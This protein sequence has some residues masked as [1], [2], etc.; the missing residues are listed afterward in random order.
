MNSY[1]KVFVLLIFLA[2]GFIF[3]CRSDSESRK[4]VTPTEAAETRTYAT[5]GVIKNIDADAGKI[6]VDHE[7]I[8]GY[9]TAMEMTERVADAKTLDAFKIGDK[10]EFE[11]RRDGATLLITK[12]NK[13]GETAVLNGGEIYKTN[14]AECH[15][16]GGE[17][18]SKGLS[19][20][21]GHALKHSEK[22][23][24]EQVAMG[25]GDKMPAFKNDLSAE[26]IAAVVK[27]V[28]EELQKKSPEKESSEHQH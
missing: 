11:L 16:G 4:S 7:E 1:P 13:I 26:Q 19:F 17:G 18:T 28:R 8:P 10:I 9:M 2:A 24:I 21:K 23:F 27:Y 22:D 3:S 6:T 25:D 12:I 5:V 14:C 20:L 15:G